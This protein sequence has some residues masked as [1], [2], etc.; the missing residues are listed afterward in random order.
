MFPVWSCLRGVCVRVAIH[1]AYVELP[2]ST[3]PI[4]DR[5]RIRVLVQGVIHKLYSPR[6]PQG[7][8]ELDEADSVSRRHCFIRIDIVRQRGVFALV[9]LRAYVH[10]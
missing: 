9:G 7:E 1:L 10:Y 5:E 2:R 3:T 6:P 8:L 4:P